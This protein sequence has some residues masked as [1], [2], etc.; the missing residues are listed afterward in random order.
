MEFSFPSFALALCL[1]VFNFPSWLCLFCKVIHQ[2]TWTVPQFLIS[3]FSFVLSN[4]SVHQGLLHFSALFFA[5]PSF[6]SLHLGMFGTSVLQNLHWP[7]ALYSI[8]LWSP[9]NIDE[10]F[11]DHPLG[12][13][14]FFSHIFNRDFLVDWK[15]MFNWRLSMPIEAEDFWLNPTNQSTQ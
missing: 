14:S 1:I 3:S 9:S 6:F 2:L 7:G 11:S 4:H 13:Q 5:P 12:N 15:S 10:M 8:I